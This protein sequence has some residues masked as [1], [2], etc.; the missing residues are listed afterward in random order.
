MNYSWESSPRQLQHE[1]IERRGVAGGRRA[2]PGCEAWPRSTIAN[3]F[4]GIG[5]RLT[6]EDRRIFRIMA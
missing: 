3:P 2:C 5:F 6:A 1:F 4:H